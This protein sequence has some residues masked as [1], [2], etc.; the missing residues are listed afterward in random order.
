[1]ML[2]FGSRDLRPAAGPWPGTARV[3]PPAAPGAL[4]S[5]IVIR[6]LLPAAGRALGRAGGPAA[7]P[8]GRA[9]PA[10]ARSLGQEAGLATARSLNFTRAAFAKYRFQITIRIL[11]LENY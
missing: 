11:F 6:A 4:R 10:R 8:S 5:S 7:M 3:P 1:M 9:F 2:V